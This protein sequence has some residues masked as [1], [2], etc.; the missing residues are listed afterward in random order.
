VSA[1]RGQASR[2]LAAGGASL[3]SALN[4]EKREANAKQRRFSCA[5]VASARPLFFAFFFF[6]FFFVS[7][8]SFVSFVP[9]RRLVQAWRW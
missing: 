7:F 1:K 2:V 8:V 4:L 3:R 5:L 6:V 9:S